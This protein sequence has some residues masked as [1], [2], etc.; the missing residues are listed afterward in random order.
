MLANDGESF[1]S[2]VDAYV[3][4]EGKTG[5]RIMR[6][7]LN[8]EVM[9]DNVPTLPVIVSPDGRWSAFVGRLA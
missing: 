2:A 1:Y 5:R 8:G 4:G 7:D 9:D 3:P 6:F